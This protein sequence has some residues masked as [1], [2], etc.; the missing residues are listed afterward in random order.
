MAVLKKLFKMELLKLY[1]G[2]NIRSSAWRGT[3]YM[4]ALK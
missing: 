3:E 2:N 1:P 4:E